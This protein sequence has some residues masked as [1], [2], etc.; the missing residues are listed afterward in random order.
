MNRKALLIS[1]GGT[2]NPIAYS[3]NH[4]Q[5]A[6]VIF[7]A[8]PDSRK[9]V[10]QQIRPLV[11]QLWED[12]EII[13]TPDPQDLT[14]CLRVL[15]EELPKK[16]DVLQLA[17][18]EVLVDYTGGTKTMSAAVVLATIDKPVVYNYVGGQVR[19][20]DGLGTVLD[21]SEAVLIT[22]NPWDVLATELKRRMARQFNQARFAEAMLTAELAA[23]KVTPTLK[24][25][26]T[27]F[28]DLFEGYFRWSLFDYNRAVGCLRK[29]HSH[30]KEMIPLLGDAAL[31]RF[32]A[33]VAADAQRLDQIKTAFQP[34]QQNQRVAPEAARALVQDLI[35]NAVR[36]VRLG[37]RADDGVAR[38]Y[39]AVEKLAKLALLERGINNSAAQAQQIPESL[40][41]V[42]VARYQDEEGGLLR[43]GLDASY[44]L[45]D[46]LGDP[47][48]R[49]YLAREKELSGVLDVRNNSLM[50]HGWA[51]VQ[52]VTFNK[53]LDITLSF[54][55]T[56]EAQLP[57]LPSLPFDDR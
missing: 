11:A 39:S 42:Y 50:V 52:E 23:S 28:Q 20:K 17:F 32:N 8:S 35:V 40:R 3:I 2:P 46:A 12:A 56:S 33:E 29:G 21:G 34:L 45:L 30:L 47:L 51:P 27:A 49:H 41:A 16:L 36:A 1:V 48:G 44:R 19:N 24:P 31:L 6:K 22:P 13:T 38:L 14:V 43:F 7:F 26:F 5:P 15:A 57:V 4:Y 18:D 55:E 10:E 25:L 54:I 9:Q 37:S 53:M